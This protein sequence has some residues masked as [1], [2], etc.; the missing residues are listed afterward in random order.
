M[1]IESERSKVSLLEEKAGNLQEKVGRQ[2]RK[3]GGIN[4]AREEDVQVCPS[5][6]VQ[7]AG[8]FVCLGSSLCHK[9]LLEAWS[10]LLK[11]LRI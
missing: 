8:H 6:P 10:Q 1:Q 9:C 11:S 3:M 2:R 7:S 4:A 5:S